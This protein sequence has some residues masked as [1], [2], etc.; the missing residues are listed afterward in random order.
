MRT[1]AIYSVSKELKD[2]VFKWF[3]PPHIIP[4]GRIMSEKGEVIAFKVYNTELNSTYILNLGEILQLNLQGVTVAGMSLRVKY[5]NDLSKGLLLMNEIVMEF[6]TDCFDYRYLSEVDIEGRL[7]S[8]GLDVIVGMANDHEFITLDYNGEVVSKLYYMVLAQE[9]N[10]NY[11]NISK[12]NSREIA[13][14]A[15]QKFKGEI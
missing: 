13:I 8:K 11:L 7:I 14:T 10:T 15:L 9:Y 4:I 1:V 5:N 12:S 2:E 6:D 3:T